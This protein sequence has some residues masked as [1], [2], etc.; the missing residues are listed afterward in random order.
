MISASLLT[1]IGFTISTFIASLA[2]T[3]TVL[4]TTSKV[5]ILS[6]SMISGAF[7]FLVFRH[8]LR[9]RE[10]ASFPYMAPVVPET[11]NVISTRE[12]PAGTV[13]EKVNPEI[14]AE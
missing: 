14:I 9:K 3:D 8:V 12:T 7:G 10:I 5:A 6:A 2:I 1:G 11:L 13:E 4:L